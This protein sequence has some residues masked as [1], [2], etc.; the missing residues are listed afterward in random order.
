MKTNNVKEERLLATHISDNENFENACLTGDADMIRS[1]VVSEMN[2]AKLHT[3]GSNKLRD[4]I[5]KMLQGKAKVSSYI[6]Q[7]VLAF[8]W[9][10][11]LSGIGLAVAK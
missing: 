9:N 7:N 6:G 8:V 11:R 3:K 10:S 5:F 2:K 1:I 4:D